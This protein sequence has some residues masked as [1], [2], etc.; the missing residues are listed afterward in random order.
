MA[1]KSAGAAIGA[2]RRELIHRGA[3]GPKRGAGTA[4]SHDNDVFPV[5]PEINT[6]R[7]RALH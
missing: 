1:C 4:R 6:P 3:G 7:A 2:A 5:L